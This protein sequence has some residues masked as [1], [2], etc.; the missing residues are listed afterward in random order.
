MAIFFE[1]TTA[2]LDFKTLAES[3]KEKVMAKI[4]D[5]TEVKRVLGYV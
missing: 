5:E 3:A 4:T 2:C 1:K